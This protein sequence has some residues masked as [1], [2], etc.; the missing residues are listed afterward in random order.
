MK[1]I[2][3]F[4]EA[5]NESLD[6]FDGDE[7]AANVFVTKYALQDNNGSYLEKTPYD[8]HNRLASEFARIEKK[9]PN[10]MTETEIFSLLQSWLIANTC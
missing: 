5:Y 1:N 4:D 8:M 10:P 6:Y 7:L 2:F 3:T 9:Y